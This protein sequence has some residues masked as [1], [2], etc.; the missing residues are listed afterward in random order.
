[1]KP[2]RLSPCKGAFTLVELLVVIAL[3]AILAAILFPVFSQAR[4][5]A[6]QTGSLSNLRQLGL[7]FAMYTQDYDETL[8][9]LYYS[10]PAGQTLPDNLG[11]WRWPWLALPYVK[12]RA[13]F[14]SPS[15]TKEY[16]G[17]VCFGACRNESNPYFGYLWGLF[18]SYGYNWRYLAPA[19]ADPSAAPPCPAIDPMNAAAAQACSR[20]LSL[21]A[22]AQPAETVLLADSIWAPSTTSSQLVMGYLAINPPRMWTG[23][24]PLTR[25]SYGFVWPRHHNQANVLWADG[26]VKTVAITRLRDGDGDGV[27]DDTLFDR[28]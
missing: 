9:P 26:H 27:N 25:T 10:G 23:N 8:P 18:P 2:P 1:M 3:I 24:P 28:E 13:L 16:S 17:S 21:G 20:G 12:S 11:A 5:K 19:Q 15:D 7:A 14:R 6:R 22:I 4:E